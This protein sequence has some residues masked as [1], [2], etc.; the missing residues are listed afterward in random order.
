MEIRGKHPLWLRWTHWLNVPFLALMIW[1]GILIYWANDV[2][3]PFFPEWV[4]RTFAIDH[5][6]AE[7]M[8][9]HFTMAWFFTINGLLYVS[10][11]LGTGHW[12]ELAPDRR[13]WKELVPTILHELGLRGKMPSRGKF[14]AAQRVAYTAITGVAAIEVLSGF[15]IYKPIQLQWLRDLFGGYESARLVHFIGMLTL[16]AFVLVHVAQVARA[17]WDNL[18]SMIAGFEVSRK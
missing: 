1:S 13:S 12:R 9:I 7:G 8:A 11:A 16:C 4:Y 15:A 2:Y 6:L 14:N 5:R 10:L 17:G 18:R 3:A